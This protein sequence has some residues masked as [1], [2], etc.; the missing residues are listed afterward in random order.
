MTISAVNAVDLLASIKAEYGGPNNLQAYYRGGSYVPVSPATAGISSSSS[1]VNML[2]FRGTSLIWTVSVTI[3][4]NT[5]NFNLY[6]YLTS[7]YGSFN[8]VTY[9]SLYVNSGVTLYSNST[10]TP[11]LDIGTGW[12]SGSRVYLY[13]SGTIIG[14]G[15]DGGQGGGYSS[16]HT[17]KNG[18]TGGPGIKKATNN[19]TL[20]INNSG[21]IAGGGGGGGGGGNIGW[22]GWQAYVNGNDIAWYN[23]PSTLYTA[24]GGG[25]G[26]AGGG[27]G[28][29]VGYWTLYYVSST[30]WTVDQWNAAGGSASNSW[31]GQGGGGQRGYQKHYFNNGIG[32]ELESIVGPNYFYS[33]AGG[34]GG[35]S[36]S[37]GASGAAADYT[38]GS[39]IPTGGGSTV[40]YGI[41]AYA[42]GSGGASGAA[43]YFSGYAGPVWTAY[44]TLYGAYT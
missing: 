26:G 3:T 14:R 9:V 31:N 42:G 15:G 5:L 25:G 11:A 39:A 2:S 6:D 29:D 28:G 22:T 30:Q 16:G 4:G 21:I 36:G 1:N 44:G 40:S 35:Q 43:V 17:G 24:G 33:G 12:A 41:A 34:S 37:S 23:N 18:G 38:N 8:A 13:N 10:S 27:A 19:V 7:T 32:G 20:Y